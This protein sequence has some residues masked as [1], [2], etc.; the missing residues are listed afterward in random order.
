[1]PRKTTEPRRLIGVNEI[2]RYL[3]EKH[4][5]KV[6]RSQFWEI[7]QREGPSRFPA[8]YGTGIYGHRVYAITD[9]IDLWMELH[10]FTP[11]DRT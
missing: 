2:R 8:T 5:I 3:L 4:E 7:R 1:M 6:S 9:E 11:P 10:A